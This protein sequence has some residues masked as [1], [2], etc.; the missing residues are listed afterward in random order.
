MVSKAIDVN[1]GRILNVHIKFLWDI[2]ADIM[3]ACLINY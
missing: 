2:N 3:F 1:F